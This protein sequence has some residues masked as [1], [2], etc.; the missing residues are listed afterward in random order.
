MCMQNLCF[1]CSERNEQ[2]KY[3]EKFYIAQRGTIKRKH[4]IMMKFIQQQQQQM[5]DEL[6][7]Y[8]ERH[9]FEQI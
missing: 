6:K 5:K 9:T 8:N 3:R 1:S 2:N 4:F 7:M